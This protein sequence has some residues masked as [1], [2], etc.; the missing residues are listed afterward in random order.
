MDYLRRLF[1]KLFP[2]KEENAQTS[3]VAE[4]QINNGVFIY[5]EASKITVQR[6]IY[7]GEGVDVFLHYTHRGHGYVVLLRSFDDTDNYKCNLERAYKLVRLIKKKYD[8][9]G[10]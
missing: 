3:H 6:D 1:Y 7:G 10:I 9:E 2:D 5:H 4:E 8:K